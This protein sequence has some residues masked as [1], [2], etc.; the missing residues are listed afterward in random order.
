[1]NALMGALSFSLQNAHGTTGQQQ[2]GHYSNTVLARGEASLL[3]VCFIQSIRRN[4]STTTTEIGRATIRKFSNA[5]W[6]E[7]TYF[8]CADTVLVSCATKLYKNACKPS[9]C[10][11]QVSVQPAQCCGSPQSRYNSLRKRF[12]RTKL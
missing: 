9:H 3:R 5:F 2:M 7:N 6:Q 12:C 10:C 11:A 8:T 4:T 1:M